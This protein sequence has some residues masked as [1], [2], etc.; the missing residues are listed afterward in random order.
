[1]LKYCFFHAASE[2]ENFDFILL[3]VKHRL[4]D[5]FDKYLTQ[6]AYATEI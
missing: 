4:H 1:M 5:Y 2:M 6:K 3:L